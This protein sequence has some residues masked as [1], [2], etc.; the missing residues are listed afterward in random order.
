MEV[1]AL[2]TDEVRCGM[3]AIGI[4]R[5]NSLRGVLPQEYESPTLSIYITKSTFI[6]QDF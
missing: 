6:H 2:F 5:A 4:A 1:Q 3:E